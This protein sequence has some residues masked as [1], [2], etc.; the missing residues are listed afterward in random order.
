MRSDQ[1]VQSYSS[2]SLTV[3]ANDV[4]DTPDLAILKHDLDPTGMVVFVG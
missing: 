1:I 4:L 2:V 3:G